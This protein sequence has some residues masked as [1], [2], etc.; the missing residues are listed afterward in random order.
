MVTFQE[1]STSFADVASITIL[2]AE[3]SDTEDRYV[4]LGMSAT[5]R[6]LVVSHTER[7]ASIRLIS[8]RPANRREAAKYPQSQ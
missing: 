7:G 2:D 3:H 4:L 1:A 5:G 6:L 8:A